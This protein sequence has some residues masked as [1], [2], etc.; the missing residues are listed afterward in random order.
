MNGSDCGMFAC[1]FSEYLSRFL[2]SVDMEYKSVYMASNPLWQHSLFK[3][4]FGINWDKIFRR[5]RISFSQ[6]N[7]PLFR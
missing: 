2:S 4:Y 6:A 5:K 1:K 3:N 7:M